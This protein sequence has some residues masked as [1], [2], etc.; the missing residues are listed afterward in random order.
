MFVFLAVAQILA[1]RI[2]HLTILNGRC[3]GIVE[4][5]VLVANRL[6]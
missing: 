2:S 6:D 4:T 1:I 3:V 5:L